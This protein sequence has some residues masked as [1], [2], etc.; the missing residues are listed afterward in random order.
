[1]LGHV[2]SLYGACLV[3]ERPRLTAFE[4]MAHAYTWTSAS[5]RICFYRGSWV[6]W[7]FSVCLWPGAWSWGLGIESCFRFL[8]WSLLL[9][10]PVSLPLSLSLYDE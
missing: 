7:W 10:L 1:M 9:P 3:G 6:A 5:L 8:A 2:N 4:V